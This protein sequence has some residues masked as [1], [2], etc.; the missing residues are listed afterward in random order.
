MKR[1]PLYA[2]LLLTAGTPVL[3][4]SATF[5]LS[6]P[7]ATAGPASA[8]ASGDLDS[9]GNTDLVISIQF[10]SEV[11]LFYSDGN[12]QLE[13]A[14][15]IGGAFSCSAISIRDL[16]DD[17]SA[18][19]LLSSET[20]AE[21]AVFAAPSAG[22]MYSLATSIA[23]ASPPGRIA[24]LDFDSD[25]DL[26][27]TVSL[28]PGLMP[29]G[30]QLFAN[31]GGLGFESIG[32]ISLASVP[33]DI[34]AADLTDDGIDDLVV[35]SQP[36][37]P[38]AQG[39]IALLAGDGQGTFSPAT[40][41]ASGSFGDVEVC[42]F[43]MNGSLD[44]IAVEGELPLACSKDLVVWLNSG[45]GGFTAGPVLDTGCGPL[46][47]RVDDFDDNGTLDVLAADGG[48]LSP[49]LNTLYLFSG[50]GNGGFLPAEVVG[51]G[52][53]GTLRFE[54]GDFD[55]TGTPDLALTGFFGGVSVLLN[56]VALPEFRRGDANN[57][58]S[59]DISDAV[60]T[61]SA[62]FVSGSDT[63]ACLDA[64]DA[65]D[66]GSLDVSDA[67][68]LLGSLFAIGAP[69]TPPPGA[70]CGQDPTGDSLDCAVGCS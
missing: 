30:V 43:D 32:A 35:T 48:A 17:G 60:S 21:V 52:D 39:A 62:L 16:D 67:V 49:S 9:D 5:G 19:I 46:T 18:E 63:L 28:T 65:N 1:F 36:S 64:A 7:Y 25:N 3:A 55:S 20:T 40:V 56:E 66:D 42:D 54:I 31:D 34:R 2:L 61:L 12:G 15:V 38:T 57:D 26:D 70:T 47:V 45:G 29:G 51:L 14:G 44:L 41:I 24:F 59:I 22:G 6:G 11:E 10:S 53:F 23:T 37:T 58:A 4:Q 68:F 13:S 69:G 27:L 8:I 33:I 50:I